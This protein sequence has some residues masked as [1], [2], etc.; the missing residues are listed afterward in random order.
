MNNTACKIL[1]LK[2]LKRM[3]T[4][5][6]QDVRLLEDVYYKLRPFIHTHP[7][8]NRYEDTTD[9]CHRCGSSKIKKKGKYRTTVS[10]F[11][12]YQCDECKGYSRQYRKMIGSIAR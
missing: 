2:Q 5:C 3:S 1:K 12:T 8:I 6:D 9:C 10:E 7:N 11:D 4:Y